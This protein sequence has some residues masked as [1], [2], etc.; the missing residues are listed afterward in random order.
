M[1][2]FTSPQCCGESMTKLVSLPQPAIFVVTNRSQLVN[3]INGDEKA[4]KLPGT[5]K[6]DNRYKEV[7]KK[8]LSREKEVIG[9][10]F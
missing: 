8:S 2:D 4:R 9:A 6:H 5:G 7:I 3:T 10:G 1:G